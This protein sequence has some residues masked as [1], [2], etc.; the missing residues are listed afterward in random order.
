MLLTFYVALFQIRT[1]CTRTASNQ[2]CIAH[3][4]TPLKMSHVSF[5]YTFYEALIYLGII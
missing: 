4:V 2:F 3:D 1:K 5:L